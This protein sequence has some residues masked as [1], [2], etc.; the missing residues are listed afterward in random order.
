MKLRG[1]SGSRLYR[2]RRDPAAHTKLG[3]LRIPTIGCRCL[4]AVPFVQS[5]IYDGRV[6]PAFC[7][8]FAFYVQCGYPIYILPFPTLLA[9]VL[10]VDSFKFEGSLVA[11]FGQLGLGDL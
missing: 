11:Y 3:R 1:G 10:D 6:P 9:C 5:S 4:G 7:N 8:F 2:R